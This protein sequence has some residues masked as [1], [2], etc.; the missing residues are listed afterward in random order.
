[1]ATRMPMSAAAR[2]NISAA[3]RGKPHPHKGHPMSAATRAK[4]SAA[5][6]ARHSAKQKAPVKRRAPAMPR[7]VVA[8]RRPAAGRHVPVKAVRPPK[9]TPPAKAKVAKHLVVKGVVRPH[10]FH[11]G[12]YSSLSVGAGYNHHYT[13]HLRRARRSASSSINIRQRRHQTTVR[14]RRH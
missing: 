1:M 12:G 4:I 8:K 9:V 10:K 14:P 11:R 7:H 6:K 2:A 5:L 13:G 3:L